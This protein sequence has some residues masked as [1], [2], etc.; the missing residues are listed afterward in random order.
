VPDEDEQDRLSSVQER[1]AGARPIPG[2]TWGRDLPGDNFVSKAASY[3]VFGPDQA[4]LEIGAGYGRLF[5]AALRQRQPFRRYV[6]VDISERN[7]RHLEERFAQDSLAVVHGAI[8][9]VSLDERFDGV[10]SSLTI[11][12]LYPT[13]VPGLQNVARHLEP[14]AIVVFDLIEQRVDGDLQYVH[15]DTKT[16]TRRYTRAQVE[17]LLPQASLE[18]VALDQVVHEPG[19]PKRL[20]V[21]ARHTGT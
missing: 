20:L 16:Y 10:L 14:G 21:V 13:F 6:A 9:T 1:W 8:E 3:G 4:V 11:K 7:V 15:G 12:H 19:T 5:D 18:L 2:L 17:E